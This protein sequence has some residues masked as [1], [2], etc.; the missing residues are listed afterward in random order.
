[1]HALM[2]GRIESKTLGLA[3]R[4][5]VLSH[6]KN[7]AFAYD[8][9]HVLIMCACECICVLRLDMGNE[10]RCRS[11]PSR[12]HQAHTSQTFYATAQPRRLV[13][14]PGMSLLRLMDGSVD[15]PFWTACLS[16]H[17]YDALVGLC[18]IILSLHELGSSLSL[19]HVSTGCLEC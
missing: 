14:F 12:I 11:K 5:F 7:L 17:P 16:G 15:C 13:F 19:S 2:C 8:R 18:D 9:T 1:M 4:C 3:C 6:W 10:S